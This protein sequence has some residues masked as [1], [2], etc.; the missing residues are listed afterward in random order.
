LAETVVA[1]GRAR[2]VWRHMAFLGP[3]SSLAAE[4][5]ECAAEEGRFWEYHDRLFAAQSGRNGGAFARTNL[6]RYGAEIGLAS[7]SFGQCLDSGRHAAGVRAETDAARGRGVK[8]TPSVFVN[9]R[10]VEDWRSYEAILAA[11]D[12]ARA[13]RG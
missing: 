11:I 4:A 9:G 5:S 13:A 3:E 12:A 7:A 8:G 6:I 1:D 2:V 10:P